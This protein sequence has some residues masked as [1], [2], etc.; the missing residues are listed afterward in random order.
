MNTE[1]FVVELMT[2]FAAG[3]GDATM[4]FCQKHQIELDD[5]LKFFGFID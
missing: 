5:A 1:A 4:A 3:N 2:V